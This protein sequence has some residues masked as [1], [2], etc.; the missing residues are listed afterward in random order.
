[1][2]K[3][4]TLERQSPGARPILMDP[5]RGGGIA[6]E[7]DAKSWSGWAKAFGKLADAFDTEDTEGRNNRVNAG[8]NAGV[9]YLQDSESAI[10]KQDLS[11]R[12]L[13]NA[14]DD[15]TSTER[16][17]EVLSK[18]TFDDDDERQDALQRVIATSNKLRAGVHKQAS[19]RSLAGIE[20]QFENKTQGFTRNVIEH[21]DDGNYHLKPVV[22]KHGKDGTVYNI[23]DLGRGIEKVIKD[24]QERKKVSPEDYEKIYHD[25][26]AYSI[27][28]FNPV[29]R[30]DTGEIVA[31]E[32]AF[33]GDALLM[34]HQV[35]EKYIKTLVHGLI[36]KFSAGITNYIINAD[37]E[38]ELDALEAPVKALYKDEKIPLLKKNN[39]TGKNV[40]VDRMEWVIQLLESNKHHLLDVVKTPSGDQTRYNVLRSRVYKLKDLFEKKRSSLQDLGPGEKL[41]IKNEF[42]EK[43][44]GLQ[45]NISDLYGLYRDGNMQ[46]QKSAGFETV[47][48]ENYDAGEQLIFP[49]KVPEGATH[50]THRHGGKKKSPFDDLKARKIA[51]PTQVG[52]FMTNATILKNR[53]RNLIKD[54]QRKHK[55]VISFKTLEKDYRAFEESVAENLTS[56][57]FMELEGAFVRHPRNKK[58]TADFKSYFYEVTSGLPTK[59]RKPLMAYMKTLELGTLP[60]GFSR[61]VNESMDSLWVNTYGRSIDRQRTDASPAAQNWYMMKMLVYNYAVN[62]LKDKQGNI[63]LL[64]NYQAELKDIMERVKPALRKA[65]KDVGQTAR[66]FLKRPRHAE[67]IG[68]RGLPGLSELLNAPR[69]ET[70]ESVKERMR[71]AKYLQGHWKRFQ[72]RYNSKGD[73]IKSVIRGR[74][75]SRD[76][77]QRYSIVNERMKKYKINRN[78]FMKAVGS[79]IE[80]TLTDKRLHTNKTK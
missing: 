22:I 45:N 2:P 10:L 26:P 49:D 60:P 30:P 13:V 74:K 3:I 58:S 52:A 62:G 54:F 8:Y 12:R 51:T 67:L 23:P 17:Q 21:L 76:D 18:Y 44:H 35:K 48:K 79:L 71:M 37:S 25:N 36:S 28:S 29:K 1:M 31:Y 63:L 20:L 42:W 56:L 32:M 43:L 34:D 70:D 65:N 59:Y 6:A 15:A 46:N 40:E 16:L 7:A 39:L 69:E 24:A 80:E 55:N 47:A 5:A 9:K 33:L 68:A 64:P 11:G 4:P 61:R 14:Y 53:A 41:K 78:R 38:E 75:V 57:L 50:E 19:I 73:R 77:K 27:V 66:N 72:D